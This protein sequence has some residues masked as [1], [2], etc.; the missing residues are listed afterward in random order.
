MEIGTNMY[1][2][3]IISTGTERGYCG[4]FSLDTYPIKLARLL[5]IWEIK[6]TPQSLAI[7]ILLVSM[8]I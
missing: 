2:L 7:K 3:S 5:Y 1:N 6:F 8:P 4:E